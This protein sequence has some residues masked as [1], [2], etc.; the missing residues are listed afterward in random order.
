MR[1]GRR[2]TSFKPGQSGNPSGRPRRP[3]A[4]E[5]RKVAADVKAAARAHSAE[6]FDTLLS[7]MRSE[8][9]PPAARVAAAMAILDRGWGKPQQAFAMTTS[10]RGEM[11]EEQIVEAL[12]KIDALIASHEAGEGDG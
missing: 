12:E 5:A 2:S 4:I 3:E 9:S 8:R 6:A 11:S 7:V 10:R 1:G